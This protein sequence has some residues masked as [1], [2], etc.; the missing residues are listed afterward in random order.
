MQIEIMAQSLSRPASTRPGVSIQSFPL[1][2]FLQPYVPLI[3][4]GGKMFLPSK[5]V[6]FAQPVAQ[7]VS[8]ATSWMVQFIKS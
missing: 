5:H 1:K 2:L 3:L 4:K 7:S 6:V 8:L